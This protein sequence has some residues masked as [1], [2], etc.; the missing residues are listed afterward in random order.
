[1]VE[2]KAGG[3]NSGGKKFRDSFEASQR[4][5]VLSQEWREYEISLRGRN[6][7]SVI[8]GFAWVATADANPGGLVFYLAHISYE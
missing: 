8:G 3:I 6:L 1:M 7:S 2:F 5:F 4:F